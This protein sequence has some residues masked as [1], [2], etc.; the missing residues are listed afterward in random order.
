LLSHLRYQGEH[1]RRVLEAG[2]FD[3]KK[4]KPNEKEAFLKIDDLKDGAS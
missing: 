4:M 3:G 1:P 2:C